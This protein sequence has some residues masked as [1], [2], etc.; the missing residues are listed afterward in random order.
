MDHLSNDSLGDKWL[1]R[2]LQHVNFGDKRLTK[3]LVHTCVLLEGKASGSLNESCGTWK[4]A[5]GAYS[6][7]TI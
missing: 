1:E 2:E 3:R 7:S 5:K 6:T 4:E